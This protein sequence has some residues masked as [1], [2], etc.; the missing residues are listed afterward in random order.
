MDINTIVIVTLLL[1]II[2]YLLRE[3]KEVD[4][5]LRAEYENLFEEWKKVELA[6]HAASLPYRITVLAF[7]SIQDQEVIYSLCSGHYEIKESQ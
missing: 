5:R 7:S 4:R 2:L 6:N 3:R 1:L